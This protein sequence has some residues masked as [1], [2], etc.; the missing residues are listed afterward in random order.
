MT[1]TRRI[2]IAVSDPR[3]A[4]DL[5]RT[6]VRVAFETDAALASLPP[7]QQSAIF[8]DELSAVADAFDAALERAI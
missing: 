5:G 1:A 6:A 8:R 7:R 2:R 3:A 4:L